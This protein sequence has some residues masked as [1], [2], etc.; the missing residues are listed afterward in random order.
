MGFQIFPDVR[1]LFIRAHGVVTQAERVK[2]M[3]AWLR[4]PDYRDCMDALFDITAADSTPEFADMRELISLLREHRPASGPR[5][6]AVVTGK[7]N[8]F[9]VAQ[10]FGDLVALQRVPLRVDV[11]PDRE[12][13]WTWLRPAETAP[14]PR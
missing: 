5:K 14:D 10:S 2:A 6:L 4:D 3:L 7:S 13:A 12:Q 9:A 1:L 8:A 11:F